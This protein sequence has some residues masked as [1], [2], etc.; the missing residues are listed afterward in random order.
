MNRIF[1]KS[2]GPAA[3]VWA[4]CVSL[5]PLPGCTADEP[6]AEPA[7]ADA[8]T[9][10]TPGDASSSGNE[11][12]ADSTS[13]ST[14]AADAE[15]S[16]PESS[17][18]ADGSTDT[19][20]VFDCAPGSKPGPPEGIRGAVTGGGRNVNIRVPEQYDPTVAAPL[21]VVYAY[22]SADA[23]A[24]EDF[25]DL[26]EPALEQGYIVAYADHGLPSSPS[27]IEDLASVP[28]LIADQWCVDES[29]VF[30]TGHSDG[31]T[32]ATFISVSP[33]ATTKP[34]AL[35][36]SA[37]GVDAAALLP[38]ACPPDPFPVMVIHGEDDSVF[39]GRGAEAAQWWAACNG[40][41]DT[42]GAAQDV[43][44]TYD[45]CPAGQEVVFCGGAWGH[46]A[47]PGLDAPMLDFMAQAAPPDE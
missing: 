21:I 19:G 30:M 9:T 24:A 6:T 2:C 11:D 10:A 15:E 29:R 41:S 8:S 43:C 32:V 31:A 34:T 47:W 28:G 17:T 16:G 5:A 4:V 46:F 20:P 25:F 27:A 12:A 3:Y 44:A 13:T 7:D 26:T 42:L 36:P 37:A 39:P 23:G 14:G 38:I 45:G 40:C 18:S 22:A 33:G 35:L 1:N